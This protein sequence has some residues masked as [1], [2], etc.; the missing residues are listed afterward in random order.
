[1]GVAGTPARHISFEEGKQGIPWAVQFHPPSKQTTAYNSIYH[2]A[3]VISCNGLI[4][5][6]FAGFFHL[7]NPFVEVV[8][9]ELGN[10]K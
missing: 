9:S 7:E 8:L 5:F 3:Y 6:F 10:I 1:M 4:Y 2:F